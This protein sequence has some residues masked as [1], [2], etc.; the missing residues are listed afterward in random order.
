MTNELLDRLR[1]RLPK[2]MEEA[3]RD[4]RYLHMH[5]EVGFETQNTEKMVRERL[6]E[7]GIEILPN[8]TGVIGRI[9]QQP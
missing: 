3:V 2:V 5:P 6:T 8:K 9:G 7:L 4:R 1:A